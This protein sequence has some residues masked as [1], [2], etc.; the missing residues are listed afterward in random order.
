MTVLRIEMLPAEEGDSL[1]IEYGESAEPRRMLID[2]GVFETHQALRDKIK[3]N[4]GSKRFELIAVTH[5][6]NDHIDAMVKLLGE[7]LKVTVGDFWFNAW[8]Q[9]KEDTLGPKQGEMLTLRIREQGWEHHSKTDGGPIGIPS[10]NSKKLPVFKFTGGMKVT[11][12]GPTADDLRRL[13]KEWRKIIENAGLKPG[14]EFTGAKLIEKAPKYA[15]DRLGTQP[16]NVER[17]ANRKFTP[18]TKPANGSSITLL[19]EFGN[20]KVLL[21]GDAHSDSLIEGLDRLLKERKLKRL[22]IDAFKLPHHGSKN[23]LSNEVMERLDCKHFLVSSSG[24]RFNH[25]DDDAIARVIFHSDNPVL[26]FNYRSKDNKD[27]DRANWKKKLQ[28]QTEYPAA[29]KSGLVVEFKVS[30]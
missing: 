26:H 22:K 7:D 10:D 3:A 14:G 24:R 12:L 29:G 25:P 30:L 18:D 23:N 11:V 9:I 6:D 28:Y 5:I 17:W 16:P 20:R 19:L 27:W 4:K 21:T 15:K 2:G 1:W 13:R 8:D